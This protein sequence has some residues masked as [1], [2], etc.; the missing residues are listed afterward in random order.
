M[1]LG[2]TWP[3]HNSRVRAWA[4]K[5]ASVCVRMQ[6][7]MCVGVPSCGASLPSLPEDKRAKRMEMRLET[8]SK[9]PEI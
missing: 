6:G 8:P 4:S 2:I 1:K 3:Q 5:F 9:S 7:S